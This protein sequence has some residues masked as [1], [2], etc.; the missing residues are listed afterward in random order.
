MNTSN[1]KIYQSQDE[2]TEV[3]VRFKNETVWLSQKQM[4]QLFDKD[5]ETV[6]LHLKNIYKSG[7]LD[8]VLTTEESSVVQVE[9]K[10]NGILFNQNGNKRIADNTLVALTSMIA[11]SKP[12][13]KDKM[14]KV[15]VNLS[16]KNN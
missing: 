7:E 4:A 16:N 13:E 6:G 2:Q 11:V 10:R 15:I 1:I 3:Q 5:T 14:T 8:E 9:G 12:D